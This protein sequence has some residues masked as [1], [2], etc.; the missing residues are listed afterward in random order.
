MS[1]PAEWETSILVI[2]STADLE[3]KKPSPTTAPKEK[4]CWNA[5][6]VTFR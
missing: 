4:W 5:E 2:P 3:S 6:W 1:L